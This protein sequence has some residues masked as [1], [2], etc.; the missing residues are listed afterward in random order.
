MYCEVIR[1]YEKFV[2]LI[3]WQTCV[4][5][6]CAC[7]VYEQAVTT[8]VVAVSVFIQGLTFLVLICSVSF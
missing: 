4:D 1:S 6:H 2:P 8:R 3:W 7:L 5:Y